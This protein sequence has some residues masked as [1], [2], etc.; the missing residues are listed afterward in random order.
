VASIALAEPTTALRDSAHPAFTPALAQFT[1]TTLAQMD[2]V[3]LLN[4]FDTKYLLSIADLG[5]LLPSLADEYVA[6]EVDGRRAH[7]YRTLY[8]DTPAFDLYRRHHQG[9]AVRHKVR[10]RIYADTGLA[11]FEIKAKSAQGRTMKYR[12]ATESAITALTLEARTLLAAHLPPD[13]QLVEPKLWNDF[14]RITLVGKER[15]ERLTL[16]LGVQYDYEGRTAILP[17]VAICEL[18]QGGSDEGSAF[19]ERMQERGV[20]ATSISKYCVGVA[21]LVPGVE[22]DAYRDKLREIERVALGA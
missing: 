15:A 22:Q 7:R 19:V 12:L 16:D 4:R 21:L 13:E 8:F 10:S 9:L 2:K 18:K 20:E 3:A 14:V 6:L 17:G 5:V 11:F 1:P